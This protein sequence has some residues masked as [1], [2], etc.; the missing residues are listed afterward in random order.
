MLTDIQGLRDAIRTQVMSLDVD[1]IDGV[2]A[3]NLV[4]VFAEIER[5]AAAGKLLAM[6]RVDAT[7]AWANTGKK[8]PADWLADVSGS[9][10]GVA[11]EAVELSRSL[12]S[13]PETEQSLRQ[14]MLSLPQAAAVTLAAKKVPGEEKKLLVTAKRGGLSALKR[15]AARVIAAAR[16]REEEA[17]R[18][19]RQ[20]ASR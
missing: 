7:G 8:S 12:E 20:R 11:I 15:E 4:V 13:L 16:S 10:L 17:A 19:K 18:A 9:G 5:I 14:G 6:G 2:A 3:R 1:R